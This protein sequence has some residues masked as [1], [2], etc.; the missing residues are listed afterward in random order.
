V[1]AA[2][3]R[4]DAALRRTQLAAALLDGVQDELAVLRHRELGRGIGR[5]ERCGKLVR[6]QQ[7]FMRQDGA[8][9]HVRCRITHPLTRPS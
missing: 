6:S 2:M 7:G 3:K 4:F 8:I 9:A 1:V 5:C